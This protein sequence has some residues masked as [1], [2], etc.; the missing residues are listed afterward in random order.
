MAFR[1]L[2]LSRS[3]RSFIR[4]IVIVVAGVLIALVLQELVSDWRDERR[5]AA[6]RASMATEIA[7]FAEILALRMRAQPCIEA[8]LDA[9]EALLGR[10]GRT[11]P[12]RNVGRPSFFFSSQGAWNS[13]ASDLLSTELSAETFRKYGEIYEGIERYGELSQ[14]EQGYWIT[15]QSLERQDEP[16]VG[17]RRWRLLEAVAG[18]RNVALL[19]NAIAEQ[20]TAE[21]KALGIEANGSMAGLDV[22]ATPICRPLATDRQPA[23]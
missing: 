6:L 3:S 8:K 21:A 5:T 14:R 1:P 15:L 16:I 9:V 20:M 2:R 10:S 17:E 23:A 18:A 12:W 19:M 4:E 11:G 22:A 7:D 13:A